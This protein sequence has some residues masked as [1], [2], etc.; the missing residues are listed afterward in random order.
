MSLSAK[1]KALGDESA[2]PG[3][4]YTDGLGPCKRGESPQG[5]IL[6]ENYAPG[7]TKREHFA[8]LIAAG[9]YSDPNVGGDVS[10]FAVKQAD[11][12]LEELSKP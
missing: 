4:L 5:E 8:I 2:F 9:C 1:A 10:E 12:L 7:L 6:Y 3:F 11:A